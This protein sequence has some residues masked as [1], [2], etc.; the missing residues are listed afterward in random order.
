MSRIIPRS[1]ARH[2]GAFLIPPA[3]PVVR[4]FLTYSVGACDDLA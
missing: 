2:L 1:V 3:L 4:D